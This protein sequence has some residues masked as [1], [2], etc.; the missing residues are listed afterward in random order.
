MN[1]AS[2]RLTEVLNEEASILIATATI[3][4]EFTAAIALANGVKHIFVIA[5]PTLSGG[6]TVDFG[7]YWCATSG[8]SYASLGTGY[9]IT[10]DSTGGK[11]HLVEVDTTQII[12]SQSTA[13]YIKG[14][15]QQK[16]AASAPTV[17]AFAGVVPFA[18]VTMADTASGQIVTP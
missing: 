15:L 7:V 14:Y 12:Q 9:A 17:T 16:V 10:T 3:G 11:V 2:E 18:P 13:L 6:A 8:G 5:V 4:S 1:A